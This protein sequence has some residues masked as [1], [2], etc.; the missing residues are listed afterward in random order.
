MVDKKKNMLEVRAISR[1]ESG[2]AV[3]NGIGFELGQ[4]RKC[5][6]M[7]ETGSG[8]STLLKI[9][10]GLVQ[11][12]AGQVFFNGE[13]VLG[14][15]EVLIPGHPGI[16]YL[17]QHFELLKNYKVIELM[18]MASKM[19]EEAAGLVFR[20]CEIEH[21]LQR[22]TNQ[23]SGGER[24]RIALARL[25][26]TKPSLLL[27][28]EPFTNLDM[29]HKKTINKVVTE[30]TDQLGI[31]CILVSHDPVDVLSWAEHIMIMKEGVVVQEGTPQDIYLKPTD[32]YVAGLLGEFNLI[33]AAHSTTCKA[34]ELNMKDAPYLIRPE[35]IIIS[36]KTTGG[37]TGEVKQVRFC[38]AYSAIEVETLDAKRLV[39]THG[40]VPEK[41]E[42]VS[43]HLSH[44][45][46]EQKHG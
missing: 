28:D 30:L 14:P 31:H 20:V 6:V 4:Y 10:A 18:E 16:A 26:L 37:L 22:K 42:K 25:L 44:L 3:V 11:P 7:G 45:E 43:L 24:Q 27:L 46:S 12:N 29:Q 17:S 33:D 40:T 23:L 35:Q 38:G 34:W 5:A 39:Y 19:D 15:E 1:F 13:R 21:L 9:I 32:A 36:K 8:K 2:K 41:G